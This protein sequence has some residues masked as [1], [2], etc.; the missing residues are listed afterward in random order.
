MD[1]LIIGY[2]NPLRGDDGVGWRVVEEVQRLK[3]EGRRLNGSGESSI[4]NFEA[5]E[6]VA[7]HQLMPELA[8][9]ISRVDRVI[10]VD[11]AVGDSP[12]AIRVQV[13]TAVAPQPGAFTHHVD[14][15]GLLAYAELLYGRAPTAYLV[16]INADQ[17]GYEETL[18]PT[19]EAALPDLLTQIEQL[20]AAA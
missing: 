3:D 12:G 18:S 19:I 6:V 2:G 11:A 1:V 13:V 15:A 9:V 5:I 10:F 20:I 17:M 8:E 4:F 14:P 16:T 7:C